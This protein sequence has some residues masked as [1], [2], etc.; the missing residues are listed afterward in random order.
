LW[1]GPHSDACGVGTR[2]ATAVPPASDDDAK[3][4]DFAEGGSSV[5]KD[6]KQGI[7]AMNATKTA[8]ALAAVVL[9]LGLASAHA[10]VSTANMPVQINLLA[11]CNVSTVAPTTLD[12][13]TGVGL[14]NANIDQTSTI[15]VTCSNSTGYNIG[16][17]AGT[18]PGATVTTRSMVNGAALVNYR[19]YRDSGRTQNWGQTVGTDTVAGTGNGTAQSISVYGR[20]P[21]QTTPAAGTYTDTV[22]VTVTY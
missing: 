8:S 14:L 16:L 15:T 7:T 22:A 19:L 12:F 1:A 5:R 18:A 10:D 4:I 20:V 13:G 17:G 2:F 21:V 6:N 11:T 3:G 9:G